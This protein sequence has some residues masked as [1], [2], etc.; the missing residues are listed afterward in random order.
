[1]WAGGSAC[2]PGAAQHRPET[3]T[4]ALAQAPGLQA[5]LHGVAGDGFK[6]I[7]PG[8]ERFHINLAF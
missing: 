6:Q 3:D 7:V 2:L 4:P 1:V 8:W 5:A